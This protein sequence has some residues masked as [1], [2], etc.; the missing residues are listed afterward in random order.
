MVSH[1]YIISYEGVCDPVTET[2]FVGCEDD[3]CTKE[4]HYSKIQK[5][6]P[7]LYNAC[8]KTIINCKTANTCL[9]SDRGCSIT[10]CDDEIDGYTCEKITEENKTNL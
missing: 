9:P 6:A 1:D 4:Y 2:C 5:Y 3:D 10:Y 8:G 7:D